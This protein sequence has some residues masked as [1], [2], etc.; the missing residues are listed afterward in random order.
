MWLEGD[1]TIH[2]Q[3]LMLEKPYVNASGTLGF[4]PDT[5]T[6][7]FLDNL[8]AF[9]TNPISY[10][11]R[12]PASSRAY[13]PYE[14]GFLLHT[15]LPN[16]GYK[17]SVSRFKRWWAN[18][19]L[20]V[21]AHLLVETPGI[22]AEMVQKFEGLENI[23]ALEISLPPDCDPVLL[24]SLLESAAGELPII[25]YLSPDQIPILLESLKILNPAAVH[26]GPPRGTLPNRAGELVTG[27]LYG[28]ALFP[29]MLQALK[30]LVDANLRPIVYGGISTQHQAQTLLDNGAMGVSLGEALWRIDA[31]K[32]FDPEK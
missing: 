26:L 20:P 32:I 13:L 3:D 21:I 25:V 6:M 2:K 8:G 1:S 4:V 16:P 31:G 30:T 29:V 9:I 24:E 18:A 5:R 11:P 19:P 17:H 14:G 27:R 23:M 15:G 10:R 12:Q 7:P 28:P 22:L